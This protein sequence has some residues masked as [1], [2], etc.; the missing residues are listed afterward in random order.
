MVPRGT[1]AATVELGLRFQIHEHSAV[2]EEKRGD[3]KHAVGEPAAFDTRRAGELGERV[4]SHHLRLVERVGHAEGSA[5][6]WI[7]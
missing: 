3:F 6:L 2:I 1:H 4:P 7:A 5:A